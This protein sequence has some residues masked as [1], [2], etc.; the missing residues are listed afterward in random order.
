MRT[1]SF[2]IVEQH[3]LLEALHRLIV[4]SHNKHMKSNTPVSPLPYLSTE[5]LYWA[6]TDKTTVLIVS[7]SLQVQ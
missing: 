4:A 3:V 7:S 2:S 5:I 1:S 6:G